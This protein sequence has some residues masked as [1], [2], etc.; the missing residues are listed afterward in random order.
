M[1]KYKVLIEKEYKKLN[2]NSKTPIIGCLMMVKNEKKR[3]HVSLESVTGTVDCLIIYDTGSTDDT[4]EIIT[5]HCEKHKL[6]LYMIHGEFINFS[7]SRNISLDYA[8]TIPV[9]FLLLLDTN[10]ELQGGNE[11]KKFCKKEMDSNNNAYLIC[12]HWWYGKYDKYFNVRFIKARKH[13]R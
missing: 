9:H 5:K 3:I 1:S 7:E 12:Q 4:I 8:D 6:N 2:V 13:W 11:L 10:D